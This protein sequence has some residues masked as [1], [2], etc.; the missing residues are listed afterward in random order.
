MNVKKYPEPD[1]DFYMKIRGVCRND[2]ERGMVYILQHTGMHVSNLVGLQDLAI[3]D[4]GWL[5]WRRVKNKKPMRAMIPKGDI[6]TCILWITAYGHHRRS[7]RA[8]QYKIKAIGE[9]SGYPGLSPMS[10]RAQYAITMLD[11][12]MQPHEV[13]HMLGCSLETLMNHYAQIQAAR[14]VIR[15]DEDDEPCPDPG[16]MPDP[17]QH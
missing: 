12:G 4:N 14:R 7:T 10:F 3:D 9:R 8:I 13:K 6:A 15:D 1:P 16:P 2:Y 17:F 5:K 11:D